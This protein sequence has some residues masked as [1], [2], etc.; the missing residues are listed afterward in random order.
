MRWA[1]NSAQGNAASVRLW[2][3]SSLSLWPT[4]SYRAFTHWSHLAAQQICLHK[5]SQP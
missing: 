4:F 2:Q 5:F 3:F 1:P